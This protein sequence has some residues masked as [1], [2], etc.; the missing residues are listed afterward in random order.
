MGISYKLSGWEWEGGVIGGPER[1]LSE[2]GKRSYVRFWEER[3][4][5]YFLLGP[6]GRTSADQ[7][8]AGKGGAKKTPTQDEQMTVREISQATGMLVEDVITALKGMGI[9]ETENSGKRLNR[10]SPLW[11]EETLT[12][13]PTIV[14]KENVFEWVKIHRV[15]SRDPVRE[16][17][18][19]G[20][21]ASDEGDGKGEGS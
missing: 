3:I 12:G 14:R 6:P 13:E 16:G 10:D 1:P 17:G 8:A 18:F 7:A 19:L 11:D 4:A 2:M 9:L 5:R 15:D 21:W 20:E